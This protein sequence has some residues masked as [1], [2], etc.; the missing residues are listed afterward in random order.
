MIWNLRKATDV[1]DKTTSSVY[2]T[3]E[4]IFLTK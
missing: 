4:E 1:F 3:L 2:K